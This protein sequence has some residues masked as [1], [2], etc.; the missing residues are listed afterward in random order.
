[1]QGDIQVQ[2]DV[3]EK[4]ELVNAKVVDSE[5]SQFF[6]QAILD[7][8]RRSKLLGKPPENM[9]RKMT[10]EINFRLD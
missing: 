8:I 2:F 3:T 4:G 5:M 7:A 10:L 1:M 6:E 9:N